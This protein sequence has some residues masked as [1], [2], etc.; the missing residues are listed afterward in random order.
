[1]TDGGPRAAAETRASHRSV[2]LV[3]L[4][5]F[6]LFEFL[7]AVRWPAAVT[8]SVWHSIPYL[9]GRDTN[10]VFIVWTKELGTRDAVPWVVTV[11][12][13][14]WALAERQLRR[15][16]TAYLANRVT[17][18]EAQIDPSRTSSGLTHTGDT[19]PRR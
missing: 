17:A 13:A 19:R 10:A 16:K 11:V 9:A 12:F 6:R 4:V 1:M 5:T 3:Q 2:T 18:L 7:T 8:I 14:F 15:R